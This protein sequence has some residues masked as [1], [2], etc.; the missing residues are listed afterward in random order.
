MHL[1]K[2]FHYDF[3]GALPQP[4]V[5]SRTSQGSGPPHHQVSH[6]QVCRAPSSGSVCDT[7]PGYLVRRRLPRRLISFSLCSLLLI[8][9]AASAAPS[10][11]L[12]LALHGNPPPIATTAS[13]SPGPSPLQL[14]FCRSTTPPSLPSPTSTRAEAENKHICLIFGLPAS[15]SA[16]SH[17]SGSGECTV[18]VLALPY[19]LGGDAGFGKA[20]SSKARISFR[21]L[22][23]VPLV[24]MLLLL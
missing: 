5:T 18:H 14:H 2:Q 20:G 23:E 12:H 13:A 24:L 17:V 7:H 4:P 10:P 11:Y 15:S 19:G 22:A 16:D 1:E 9:C 3:V 6:Q 8:G 21:C